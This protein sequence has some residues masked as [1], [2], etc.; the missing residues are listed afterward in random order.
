MKRTGSSALAGRAG[1]DQHGQSLQVM[2]R[3]RRSHRFAMDGSGGFRPCPPEH[4]AVR[5]RPHNLHRPNIRPAP[6][7][8][9]ACSPTPR[10]PD[11]YAAPR[12]QPAV[13]L[14]HDVC[15]IR[16]FIA[17]ATAIGWSVARHSVL[18]KSLPCRGQSGRKS[19]VAGAMR[20][21]SAQRASSIW[22]TPASAWCRAEST[23][24]GW[25]DTA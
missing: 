17:G 14:G 16:R 25:P 18:S 13:V 4:R 1:G 21:R 3:E 2:G 10:S 11:V 8:P 9:Q 22:P 20:I 5:R 24:T 12:Q 19:A 23:R 7:S 6:I 15:H